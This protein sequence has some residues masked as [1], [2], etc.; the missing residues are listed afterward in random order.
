MYPHP[1]RRV[2]RFRRLWRLLLWWVCGRVIVARLQ[3]MADAE[4]S[5]AERCALRDGERPKAYDI[6][7]R[8]WNIHAAADVIIAWF[9]GH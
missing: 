8:G 6:Y 4:I 5:C 9:N 7:H 2:G 3:A 1:F